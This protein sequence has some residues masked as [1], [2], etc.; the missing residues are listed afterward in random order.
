MASFSR[1]RCLGPCAHDFHR[2][3]A[4]KVAARLELKARVPRYAVSAGLGTRAEPHFARQG[5]LSR[6]VAGQRG[7][8]EFRQGW[9]LWGVSQI[10]VG[11]S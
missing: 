3:L 7:W 1:W 9:R 6:A 8:V 10:H 2:D 5:G 11:E 4:S